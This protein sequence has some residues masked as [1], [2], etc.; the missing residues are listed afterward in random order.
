MI[1]PCSLGVQNE[2]LGGLAKQSLWMDPLIKAHIFSV[3]RHELSSPFPNLFQLTAKLSAEQ[4]ISGS[5][6]RW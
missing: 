1:D 5:I 6:G 2:I 3:R 4:R